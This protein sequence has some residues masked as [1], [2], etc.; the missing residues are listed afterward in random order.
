MQ[1]E[2]YSPR[3]GPLVQIVTTTIL[4]AALA[5]LVYVLNRFGAGS[6]IIGP[7]VAIAAALGLWFAVW[8][9]GIFSWAIGTALTWLAVAIVVIFQFG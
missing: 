8:R 9:V 5:L 3:P 7:M 1:D 4:I 2:N 6:A